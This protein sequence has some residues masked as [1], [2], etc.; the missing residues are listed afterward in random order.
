MDYM[1]TN[2]E[3][4]ATGHLMGFWLLVKP[5]LDTSKKRANAGQK[6]AKAK[7]KQIKPKSNTK[8]SPLEEKEKEKDIGVGI[9][10]TN[11]NEEAFN[12]WL[13]YKGKSYKKQSKTMSMNKLLKQPKDIQLQMVE[14]S[15]ANGWAGLF[16]PKGKAVS[17]NTTNDA[18][19]AYFANKNVEVIDAE[20]S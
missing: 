10:N 2:K 7:Q 13:E 15:I 11:L 4:S 5:T 20:L 8:P 3:P 12:M 18:I 6:K 19:D 1:F 17:N 14:D 16:E 9:G